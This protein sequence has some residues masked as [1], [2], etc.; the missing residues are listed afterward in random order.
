MF[1]KYENVF[2][3]ELIQSPSNTEFS[4]DLLVFILIPFRWSLSMMSLH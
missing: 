4:W 2:T 3:E 1:Q